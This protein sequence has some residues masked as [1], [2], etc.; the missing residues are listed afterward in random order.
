MIPPLGACL[1]P[2]W[3]LLTTP[4]LMMKRI[5]KCRMRFV[6]E[7]FFVLRF[8]FSVERF[9]RGQKFYATQVAG[10]NLAVGVYEDV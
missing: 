10:D 7:Y 1:S 3:R 2:F 8:L 5:R 4:P 9:Q 6:V